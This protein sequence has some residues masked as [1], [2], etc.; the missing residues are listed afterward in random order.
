[1]LR[2]VMTYLRTAVLVTVLALTFTACDSA[3]GT[4]SSAESI[5]DYLATLD[6]DASALLNVQPSDAAREPVD[7]TTT[8]E[9]EGNIE[10][11]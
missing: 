4:N 10:R 9:Q 3:P 6:Y 11:T 2:D 1:M 7:T 5:G 8:T